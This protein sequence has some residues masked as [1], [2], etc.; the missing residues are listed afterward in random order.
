MRQPL[1][2]A[3]SLLHRGKKFDFELL[4][5]QR[6]SGKTLQRENVRHPGAIVVVPILD[7]EHAGNPPRSG[8]VPRSVVL[9]RN[10]RISLQQPLLECCAGTI[11]RPRLADGSFGPGEA[12]E[13]CAARELIEETGY[14]AAKLHALGW[15]YTTPGLTDEQMFAFAATG[16]THVGQ[17]LEEDESIEVEVVPAAR[18]VELVASGELRDAKSMLAIL[19]AQ[20]AGFL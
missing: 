13:L 10:F 3:R 11:E 1:I 20:R 6:P 12:P 16:L 9:I 17:K 14:Q 15:F 5:V 18:A 2:T 8:G 4:T 19:L 7:T